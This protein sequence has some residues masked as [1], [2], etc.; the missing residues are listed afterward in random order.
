MKTRRENQL[1]M[2]RV[3]VVEC[4]RTL[5]HLDVRSV[6]FLSD[7][8]R[9]LFFKAKGLELAVP[10]QPPD[11]F[12]ADT[13][14]TGDPVHVEQLLR[15][16][17]RALCLRFAR[18]AHDLTNEMK[19]G[20]MAGGFPVLQT[21]QGAPWPSQAWPGSCGKRWSACCSH[22]HRVPRQLAH[23]LAPSRRITSPQRGHGKLS[24]T[25]KGSASGGIQGSGSARGSFTRTW[26]CGQT[27]E[28]L[29]PGR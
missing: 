22:T 18:V 12:L 28:V 5:S 13:E 11:L 1:T 16:I 29:R 6:R 27:T 10:D 8:P 25:P 15:T 19:P 26:Q 20:G 4:C 21:G 7:S 14:T 9:A 17:H 2:V 3:E 23:W 24:S